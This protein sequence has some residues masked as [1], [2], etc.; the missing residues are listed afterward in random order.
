MTN[1][2]Q[3]LPEGYFLHADEVAPGLLT[4]NFGTAG[5][6]LG[7]YLFRPTGESVFVR[8]D[9]IQE[10]RRQGIAKQLVRLAHEYVAREGASVI[11]ATL[12]S[13][14]SLELVQGMFGADTVTIHELGDF[15]PEGMDE[16]PGSPT[17]ASFRTE[18]Q[19]LP[20]E[21]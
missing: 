2:E 3:I 4:F 16:C 7:G 12:E 15:A 11:L 13:R 10:K 17:K 19:P 9:V 6:S 5:A 14:E 1:P 8:L 20:N 18:I 21:R